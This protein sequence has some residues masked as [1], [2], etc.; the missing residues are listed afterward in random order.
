MGLW[1]RYVLP[2]LVDRLCG[3]EAVAEQRR[4]VVPE[5][6]GRVLEVGFGSGHNLPYYEAGRVERVIGLEPSEAM[7]ELARERSERASFPVE[8]LALEA[9][10]LAAEPLAEAELA[11]RIADES[12]DT[13]VVTFTLCTVGE[14][15]AALEGMRRVLRRG[16]RLLFAEHG[17][18]PDAAVARWQRRV[19]P[20]WRRA[21]GGCHLDRDVPALLERAGFEVE[22][23]ETGY[24]P[25]APRIA[26]F[27]YAGAA[28][29]R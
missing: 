21:F 16:G 4:R 25:D 14:P 18:A 11:E 23:L 3:G 1:E 13:V 20:L 22:A 27:V 7:L 26:A 10:R 29:P 28:R 17:R 8:P 15:E 2:R 9:E 19:N 6:E 24:V 5:A 12:V